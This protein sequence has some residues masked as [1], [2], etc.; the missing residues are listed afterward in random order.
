MRVDGVSNDAILRE[1]PELRGKPAQ[2]AMFCALLRERG[3]WAD[4]V[5]M[6]EAAIAAAP[7]SLAVR[8]EVV[9]ALSRSVA[10]FHGPMLLDRARN[11]AYASAIEAIV[12]PGMLVLEI[13]AGSGLLALIAAR[14]G[15]Q[16]VTCESNPLVAAVAQT[17]VARNGYADRVTVIAKQSD[18]LRIPEDLPRPADLVIHEI[19]GSQLFD[20][21]VNGALAD[22]RARLLTADAP[23]L[24]SRAAVRCAL[25]AA[26]PPRSLAKFDDV[27]G[28][29][30]SH[31]SLL[32][33][34]VES[35]F[36]NRRGG[37]EQRSEAVSALWM[38]YDSPPPFGTVSDTIVLKSA[39]GR[40]DGIV[41]WI[42]I[43][44]PDGSTL[45]NDPFPD[46]PNSSW[47]AAFQPFCEPIETMP[48]DAI[49]VT[50]KHRG[51][52][53]TLDAVKLAES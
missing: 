44:F 38:D 32:V 7:D 35:V 33:R 13:G 26:D 4:A 50:L 39:G 9:A 17:I 40:I 8:G 51:A 48:G 45:E 20:E 49:A 43:H 2:M 34:P 16:V 42:E 30:L 41:Q 12:T 19:F 11:A 24:P 36:A 29:D 3:Q 52:L 5:A 53:L 47:A 46:A 25:A 22:A 6:G 15:A 37:L 14:A 21:G 27:H 28:F 31:F 10:G 1:H 18:Q 23:S